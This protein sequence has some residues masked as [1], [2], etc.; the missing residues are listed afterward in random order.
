MSLSSIEGLIT[1][2]GGHQFKEVGHS[3]GETDQ[4]RTGSALAV[5][6]EK[7]PLERWMPTPHKPTWADG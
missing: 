5:V 4:I 7:T 3:R 1:R 2:R 6:R